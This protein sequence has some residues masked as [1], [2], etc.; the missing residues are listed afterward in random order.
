MNSGARVVA[1]SQRWRIIM[2]KNKLQAL[3][4]TDFDDKVTRAARPSVIDFWAPWCDPCRLVEPILQKLADRY[5]GRVEFWKMNI[6]EEKSK[7]A[8]YAVRSIPTI[9]FFKE[10]NLA[11]QLIG[12]PSEQEI[13][14]AIENL[15]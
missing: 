10:G 13:E 2:L 12:V 15:L 4:D 5:D 11:N 1:P 7:P 9:L 6:D 14:R 8:E 3:S